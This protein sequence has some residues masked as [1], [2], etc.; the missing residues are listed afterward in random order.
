MI[1]RPAEMEDMEALL[2]IEG[3]CFRGERFHRSYIEHLI[4]AEEVDVFVCVVRGAVISSAMVV[5]YRASELSR[6]L[7]L[8]TLP[9]YRGR[10]YSRTML[11]RAEDLARQNGSRKMGLE[12]RKS[13]L[14][15]IGLYEENGYRSIGTLHDFF[16]PVGDAWQMEKCL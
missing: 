7:S 10:G 4:S 5:H 13:N 12:V 2:A 16:G 9:A 1:I 15:A 11:K 14:A 6:L 8:A 3:A